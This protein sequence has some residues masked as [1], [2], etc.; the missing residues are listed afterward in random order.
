MNYSNTLRLLLVVMAVAVANGCNKSD[1]S[2]KQILD[3]TIT[4]PTSN[5]NAGDVDAL[6]G[7]VYPKAVIRFSV[8]ERDSQQLSE[9]L[10][11]AAAKRDKGHLTHDFDGKAHVLTW[12]YLGSDG[13][14][15]NYLFA[16][17]MPDEEEPVF[18]KEISYSGERSI[19][20]YKSSGVTVKIGESMVDTGD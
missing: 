7:V 2:T 9:G 11:F 3:T 6:K 16:L 4:P 17:Q 18:K 15:D 20:L 1:K 14:V 8:G 12:D 13:Q 10:H 19:V 5:E